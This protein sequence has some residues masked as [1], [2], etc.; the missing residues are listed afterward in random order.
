MRFAVL[1]T[2]FCVQ[3]GLTAKNRF[4]PDSKLTSSVPDGA[5]PNSRCLK[6]PAT[7]EDKGE[8]GG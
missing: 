1:A 8:K 4:A 5:I 7:N 3:S 6:V 2:F